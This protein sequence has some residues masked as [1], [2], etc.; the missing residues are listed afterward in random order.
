LTFCLTRQAEED[1]IG[2]YLY[3]AET[4]GIPQADAYHNKLEA[5][6]NLLGAQPYMA[7]ERTEINPPVRVHP[8]GSHIIIYTVSV[9][10]SVLVV[11]VQHGSE[12]WISNYEDVTD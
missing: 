11:R 2:I 7:R 8:C 5:T 6:F 9:D 1:V 10:E 4:F 12:D 3:T